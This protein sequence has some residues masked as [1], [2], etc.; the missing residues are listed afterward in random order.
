MGC[1]TEYLILTYGI[2]KFIEFYSSKCEN[3]LSSFESCYKKKLN[4]M[5]DEFWGYVKM[6]PNDKSVED[7]M[8][9]LLKDYLESI[10]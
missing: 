1:F 5:E 8:R 7:T 3:V 2:E 10:K 6:F 4:E 9:V